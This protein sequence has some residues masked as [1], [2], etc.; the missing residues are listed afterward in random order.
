MISLEYIVRGR[1][2]CWAIGK[3]FILI[4]IN[5]VPKKLQIGKNITHS[6]LTKSKIYTSQCPYIFS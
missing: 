1:N 3:P 2:K 5:F 4:F 6:K